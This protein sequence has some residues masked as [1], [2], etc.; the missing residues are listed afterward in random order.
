MLHVFSTGTGSESFGV[1]RHGHEHRLVNIRLTI[2][3][4]GRGEYV[5]TSPER[6][7]DGRYA[8]LI[9]MGRFDFDVWNLETVRGLLSKI[10]RLHAPAE[11]LTFDIEHPKR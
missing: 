10:V 6:T 4:N 8:A 2:H 5:V 1:Q 11:E 9:S 3:A 7:D